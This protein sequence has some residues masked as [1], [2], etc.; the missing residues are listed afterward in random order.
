M[1]V[2]SLRRPGGP[3]LRCVGLLSLSPRYVHICACCRAC[4]ASTLLH[5]QTPYLTFFFFCFF[6]ALFF[7]SFLLISFISSSS[8]SF[9]TTLS[10]FTSLSFTLTFQLS[11]FSFNTTNSYS[12]SQNTSLNH[13][14]P[15]STSSTL[16]SHQYTILI[17]K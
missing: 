17:L 8:F 4:G 16:S 9:F 12:F 13:I 5:F 7:F 15:I 14:N 1:R 6:G 10:V 2:L 3:S 11:F